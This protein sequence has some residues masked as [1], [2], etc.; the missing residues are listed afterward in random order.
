MS[1]NSGRLLDS[2]SVTQEQKDKAAVKL[3]NSGQLKI[4]KNILDWSKDPRFLL[5]HNRLNAWIWPSVWTVEDHKG[6]V[7]VWGT[8]AWLTLIP[9]L[10]VNHSMNATEYL[11][12]LADHVHPFMTTIY[13]LILAT[14]NIIKH[15]VPKQKSHLKLVPWQEVYCFSVTFAVNWSKAEM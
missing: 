15:S 10:P 2:I 7:V 4:G 5:R 13:H 9:L 6:G 12:I 11:S 14:F 3:S 8:F 1:Y